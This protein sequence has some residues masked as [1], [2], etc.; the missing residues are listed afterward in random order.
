MPTPTLNP[1]QIDGIA[2]Q[3]VA[4]G[5]SETTVSAL[6]RDWPG[7]HFTWCSDDDVLGARP[8]RSGEGFN[9]YL[10]DGRGHCLSFTNDLECATGLVVAEVAEE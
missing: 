6:R 9:L 10:V 2:G 1:E 4:L 7:V 8:V 3:V 5:A